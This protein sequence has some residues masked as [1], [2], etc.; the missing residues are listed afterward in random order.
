MNDYTYHRGSEWRKWDLHA[1]TPLDTEWI[2]RPPLQTE[3]ERKLFAEQYVETAT[4]TTTMS[5]G[6]KL[7]LKPTLALTAE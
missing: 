7:D 2:N 4:I 6:I 1:H 5:P 3:S